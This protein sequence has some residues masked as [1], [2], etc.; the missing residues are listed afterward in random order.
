MQNIAVL[1][2]HREEEVADPAWV[3]DILGVLAEARQI[4]PSDGHAVHTHELV[5]V[6]A[7]LWALASC[8]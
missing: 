6:N 7:A 5:V 2:R 3:T 8:G 1:R 4:W